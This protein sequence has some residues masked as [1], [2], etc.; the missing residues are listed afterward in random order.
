M[1]IYQHVHGT[2]YHRKIVLTIT[3]DVLKIRSIKSDIIVIIVNLKK[4]IGNTVYEFPDG[5]RKMDIFHQENMKTSNLPE[6]D[7]YDGIK[8]GP[9]NAYTICMPCYICK[10]VQA[11]ITNYGK[12]TYIR[13]VRRFNGM[14]VNPGSYT[15]RIFMGKIGFYYYLA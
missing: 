7:M 12:S 10:I 6:R 5:F 9:R 15:S 8:S 11:N 13:D 14:I 1:R 2:K 4:L 3:D